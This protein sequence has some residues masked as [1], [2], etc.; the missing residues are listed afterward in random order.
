MALSD[1]IAKSRC[2]GGRSKS[3]L[4][5]MFQ[6]VFSFKRVKTMLT[7]QVEEDIKMNLERSHTTRHLVTG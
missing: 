3:I 6:H 1:I 2:P 5:I 7:T 4:G